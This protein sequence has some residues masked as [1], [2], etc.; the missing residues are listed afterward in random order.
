[1]SV[2]PGVMPWPVV[3]QKLKMKIEIS[4]RNRKTKSQIVAGAIRR[5]TGKLGSRLYFRC[6]LVGYRRAADQPPRR[7][8]A[9]AQPCVIFDRRHN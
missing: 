4:G 1:M 2:K 6:G 7:G 8:V 3:F 9:I 5:G